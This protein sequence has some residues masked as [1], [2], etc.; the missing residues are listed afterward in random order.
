MNRRESPRRR[1][2]LRMVAALAASTFVP[3]ALVQS[4]GSA[5]SPRPTVRVSSD[6]PQYWS[7][8][9][10]AD[11]QTYDHVPACQETACDHMRLT[12]EVPGRLKRQPGGIEV[13]IRWLNAGPVDSL[14]LYAYR[15]RKL[16]ASSTGQIGIAQSLRLPKADATYDIFVSMQPL[17][18]SMG[19]AVIQYEALAENENDPLAAPV[20]VLL[21]DLVALPHRS[22][23]FDTPAPIFGD[24]APPGSSC[25][26]SE[27]DEQGAALCL[28]AGQR[29]ANVGAGPVDTRW[30]TDA[31]SPEDEVPTMQRIYRSDGSYYERHAANMHY[32][33]VH[34]H[35][36]FEAFSQSSLYPLDADGGPAGTQPVASGLKNGFC[37]ADTELLWWGV[38][39]NVAQSYPAPRCLEPIG[40]QDGRLQFKNGIGVGWADEYTWDLPDQMIEVSGLADGRYLL[41]TRVDVENSI[42][43]SD[44]TNNCLAREVVL[45]GLGTS[46]PTAAFAGES[47][48]CQS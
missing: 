23:T 11:G 33:A 30:T 21:P 29:A 8:E 39:G 36:H 10:R 2:G 38:K 44:E 4:A 48:A 18:P 35:Y 41:V 28:R 5:E 14:G 22:A 13:S 46:S 45:S 26:Q 19:S 34:A 1:P 16:V 31:T 7:A 47:R 20:R 25:F 6:E 43:E 37:M 17:D 15:G 12:V 9:V 40:E 24:T 3:F 42:L 27:I 32:H